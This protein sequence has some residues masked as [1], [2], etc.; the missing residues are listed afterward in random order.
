[1]IIL[2]N[3]G[4]AI[5]S[6]SISHDSANDTNAIIFRPSWWTWSL[7]PWTVSDLVHLVRSSDLTTLCSDRVEL[8]TTGP[9][10]T[11]QKVIKIS[12]RN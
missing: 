4:L 9:R 11:T 7:A 3:V 6:G 2:E 1:M 10:V 5:A 8:V 12:D